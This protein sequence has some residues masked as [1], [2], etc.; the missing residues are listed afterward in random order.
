MDLTKFHCVL[1]SVNKTFTDDYLNESIAHLCEEP[2]ID[3]VQYVVT[4][5]P[6]SSHHNTL[7]FNINESMTFVH[8][9]KM[10]YPDN[11]PIL[12]CKLI[13]RNCQDRGF[14][15]ECQRTIPKK[16]SMEEQIPF[17]SRALN[18]FTSQNALP[19]TNP[20][21]TVVAVV[22]PS[23]Y[24]RT[25]QLQKDIKISYTVAVPQTRHLSY[26]YTLQKCTEVKNSF[27]TNY[28]GP[29]SDG[30]HMYTIHQP[31]FMI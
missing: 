6:Q 16:Y 3:F 31:R 7:I 18:M 22:I 15:N 25:R 29:L 1:K 28:K 23:G 26:L 19:L 10:I 30:G 17:C 20:Y 21:N 14:T 24:D 9:F 12:K 13:L 5:R 4:K 27:E 2:D 8:S 11:H